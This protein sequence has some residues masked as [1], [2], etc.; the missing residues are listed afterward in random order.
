MSNMYADI[1]RFTDKAMRNRCAERL[2]AMRGS[3]APL[4]ARHKDSSILLATWNIRDFGAS[5]FNPAGRLDES[6]Y[7][8]A[9]IVSS[10]DLIAIQEVNRNLRDF[11]RLVG[12][13]GPRWRY[14]LTDA[15]E[16]TGGNGERMAFV[17][18]SE[19]V[20]FRNI[21]GEIV[22]P[23]GQLVVPAAAIEPPGA[24]TAAEASLVPNLADSNPEQMLGQQFARTP[25]LVAFQAGW[26]R[27]N[28]CTVHI[29]YGEESGPAMD[30][31][32]G[33]IK[34]L[35]NFF[36]RRQD[37]ENKNVP[38][39]HAENYILLGDFNVVSPDH[40]TMQALKSRKFTVPEQID[41]TRLENRDHFYDQ[42]AVRVT[43]PRFAILDG[44]IVDIYEDVFTDEDFAL[45]ADRVPPRPK[46]RTE[47][48]RYQSWR[49]W[50]MSDHKPLWVEVQTDFSE[51][52]LQEV[53]R[54]SPD[55]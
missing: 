53:S 54:L 46:S 10:F 1:R 29:Y 51:A 36:A 34:A 41:G 31:R 45:Y 19:K 12:I 44:G 11:D 9:E 5:K 16:G 17:Y 28:L 15:T 47:Q 26:F 49:T 13:L 50:Q 4:R 14:I 20:W 18:N 39:Q 24:L 43:D 30:R 40:L 6:F 27:F 2:V 55:A 21:A 32:I 37:A 3:L 38:P 35:V 23:S 7:Y 48:E 33:E 42:I 8:L 52:Y 22:L 25:F